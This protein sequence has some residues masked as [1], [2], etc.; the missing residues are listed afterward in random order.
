VK[1]KGCPSPGSSASASDK[2][3]KKDVMVKLL[4][5]GEAYFCTTKI[6]DPKFPF[7]LSALVKMESPPFFDQ[8]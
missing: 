2:G 3:C 8:N 7:F 4:I 5:Y 1:L 6:A